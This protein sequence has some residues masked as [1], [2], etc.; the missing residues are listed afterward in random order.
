[1]RQCMQIPWHLPGPEEARCL[2]MSSSFSLPCVWVLCDLLCDGA[3]VCVHACVCTRV[4][5]CNRPLSLLQG[6]LYCLASCQQVRD[7]T[8]QGGG[9]R[10]SE[11][12][13]GE[14]CG[15]HLQV[16]RLRPACFWESPPYPLSCTWGWRKGPGSEEWLPLSLPCHIISVSGHL[17]LVGSPEPGL[18]ISDILFLGT[19]EP[20]G[21]S[22]RNS[23]LGL[24]RRTV[25]QSSPSLLDASE[26]P[27]ASVRAESRPAVSFVQLFV[28]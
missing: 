5:A 10:E 4:C 15:P 27:G 1:M 22:E 24:L 21:E 17:T 14:M 6:V 26:K 18:L 16:C 13:E 25:A 20:G 8:G 23:G 12:V 11:G 28:N 7:Y 3:C 9:R 2:L 19:L